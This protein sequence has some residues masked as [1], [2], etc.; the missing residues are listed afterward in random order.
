MFSPF[1]RM[2]AFRYLRARR[3]EGFVSVIALFSLLGIM[4][5]VGTLIVVMAVMNG[6]REELFN[7]VI[8][9]NGHITVMST[10]G[11]MT[12][13]SNLVETLK[14]V[15][16]VVNVTPLIEG[17]AL[18]TGRG[19]PKGVLVRGIQAEDIKQRPLLASHIVQGSLDAFGE[20]TVAIGARLA[21]QLGVRV[22]ESITLISPESRTSVFG[23]L[24]RYRD[25]TVGA[26]FDVGMFEYD[27]GY[28]F[29][30]LEA[31]QV[32]YRMDYLVS[33]LEV[34]AKDPRDLAGVKRRIFEAAGGNLRVLDWQQQNAG[35]LN[36][37]QVE[38]N[39]MFLI[40]SLIIMVAAFNII[41]SLI[42]LVKDKSKDI[43]IL[44]TMGAT[45]GMI[46]RIFFL[47]GASIGVLGTLL[48]LAGGLAFA[49]N[50]ENIR[51]WLQSWTG[52][53]LF[54]AEAYF[55]SQL[56]AVVDYSDVAEVVLMALGLSFLATLY[57][58]WRAARMDPV[59]ALRYE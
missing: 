31:A 20:T 24:P 47:T 39:V 36:V 25:Y 26:I 51:Q 11:P 45:R 27:S 5:G 41:S 4:L 19:T 23:S 28:V 58:A 42:M 35:F 17:Q 38:R 7:R 37:I 3:Q 59:E 15:E 22:G 33:G 12:G 40:L 43:A 16:G 49:E 34:F 48:G 52:T 10:Q 54:S 14:P 1:E 55:L 2:M 29:M 9:I 53:E 50:I 13:Y 6:F 46:Q 8:G 18:V 30:P 32:F 21:Q 57:P 44:R 56:P